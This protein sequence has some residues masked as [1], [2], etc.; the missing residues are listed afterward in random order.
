MSVQ[1]NK[2]FALTDIFKQVFTVGTGVVALKVYSPVPFPVPACV[3]PAN[4]IVIAAHLS[5]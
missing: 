4:L 1:F 5:V 3:A 2:G